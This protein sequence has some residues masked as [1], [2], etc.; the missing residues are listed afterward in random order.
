[1]GDVSAYTGARAREGQTACESDGVGSLS[2][3][4]LRCMDCRTGHGSSIRSRGGSPRTRR[5]LDRCLVMRS[6][7][8]C[9]TW[10][11]PTNPGQPAATGPT[12]VTVHGAS[13]AAWSPVRRGRARDWGRQHARRQSGRSDTSLSVQAGAR[14]TTGSASPASMTVGASRRVGSVSQAWSYE[15]RSPVKDSARKRSRDGIDIGDGA[16]SQHGA[17]VVHGTGEGGSDR[18]RG[19]RVGVG[20]VDEVH[21]GARGSRHA[22]GGDD[23]RG[24]GRERESGMVDRGTWA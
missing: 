14:G 4:R 6:S 23:G 10:P 20:D 18:M 21:G 3:S 11:C 24:A 7:R 22:S 1:M 17:G 19:D 16:W 5:I 15:A 13:M 2:T 12:S 8:C 9:R